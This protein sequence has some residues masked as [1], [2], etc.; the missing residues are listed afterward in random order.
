MFQG[1][2]LA[3]VGTGTDSNGV[4]KTITAGDRLAANPEEQIGEYTHTL[5]VEEAPDHTHKL[6]D[7]TNN[8]YYAMNDSNTPPDDPIGR[9]GEFG[10]EARDGQYYPFSGQVW[11]ASPT[12]EAESVGG[13][14]N[15]MPPS[16]GVYIWK[17]T[18]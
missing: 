1:L 11:G 17:R 5:T 15:N 8:Q 7:S 4:E 2:F 12:A 18:S 9:R 13:S 3:G 16:Y 6:V 10:E 14:H